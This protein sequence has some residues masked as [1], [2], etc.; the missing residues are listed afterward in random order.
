MGGDLDGASWTPTSIC[1]SG[2]HQ[3]IGHALRCAFEFSLSSL[4]SGA[5]VTAA[6]LSLKGEAS[7]RPVDLGGYSGD[8]SADLADVIAGSPILTFTP[9][10]TWEY[11]DVT[12]FVQGLVAADASWA[13]FNLSGARE[14]QGWAIAGVAGEDSGPTLTIVYTVPTNTAP[15]N[16]APPTSTEQAP[17]RDSGSNLVGLVALLVVAMTA[18]FLVTRRLAL[19]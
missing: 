11:L 14:F 6:T 2:Y 8:G 13:G 16:T 7:N 19:R 1:Y 4:P 15:T 5:T 10:A 18:S 3:L 17:A 12:A 9:L